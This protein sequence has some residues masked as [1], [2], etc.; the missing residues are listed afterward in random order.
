MFKDLFDEFFPHSDVQLLYH[1]FV[2][3]LGQV[4]DVRFTGQRELSLTLDLAFYSFGFDAEAGKLV[5]H[6]LP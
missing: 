4:V 5:H 3:D 1:L 2:F 6:V